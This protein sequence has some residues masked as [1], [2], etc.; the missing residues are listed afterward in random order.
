MQ[1]LYAQ[2]EDAAVSG[3][4][5]GEAIVLDGRQNLRP[6]A[7]VVERAR[8]AGAR[9]AG[10]A[11]SGAASGAANHAAAKASA[12]AADGPGGTRPDTSS[13]TAA[14]KEKVAP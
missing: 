12:S 9:A 13:G 10:G 8:E 1:V 3:V 4:K 7:S 5:P 14:T 11:A 2:G 6:G